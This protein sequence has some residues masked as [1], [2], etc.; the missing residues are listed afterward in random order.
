MEGLVCDGDR[1]RCRNR[2]YLRTDDTVF[3][4]A[5]SVC[6]TIDAEHSFRRGRRSAVTFHARMC[7]DNG[8]GEVKRLACGSFTLA[9][10]LL[11]VGMIA[12]TVD[13]VDLPVCG[14]VLGVGRVQ[15]R[16]FVCV[17]GIFDVQVF[18]CGHRSIGRNCFGEEPHSVPGILL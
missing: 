11:L 13:D 8:T 10:D 14:S 4:P 3:L 12:Q 18:E 15:G 6:V 7:G 1:N 9:D 2:D 16:F 5:E 17:V